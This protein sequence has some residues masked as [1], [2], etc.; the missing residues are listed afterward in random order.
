VRAMVVDDSKA[1]RAVL[2]RMLKSCGYEDVVEAT[3]GVDAF[4]TIKANGSPDVVLVDWN[5]PEMTGIEFIRRVRSSGMLDEASVVM[6]TS[7]TAIEKITEALES[8][9]DEYLMKPFT[10]EALLEKLELA[11]A[12]H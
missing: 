12:N 11:R 9:A 4:R 1:M 8:G 3:N 2:V 5:M 6:V 7:E 10:L